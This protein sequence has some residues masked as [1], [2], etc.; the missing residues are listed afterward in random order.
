MRSFGRGPD[1]IRPVT[2]Q[3][4]YLKNAEGSALIEMGNTRVICTATLDNKVPRFLMGSG[5]GWVTGEYG[6]LPRSTQQRMMR[7]IKGPERQAAAGA[8]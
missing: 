2:I 3:R 6:M 7:E 5:E 1:T 8:I 4:G